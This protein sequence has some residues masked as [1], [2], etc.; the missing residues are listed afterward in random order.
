V[1]SNII[2]PIFCGTDIRP[3]LRLP[4]FHLSSVDRSFRKT[5][6]GNISTSKSCMFPHISQSINFENSDTSLHYIEHK[7]PKQT[8]NSVVCRVCNSTLSLVPNKCFHGTIECVYDFL[9]L[10]YFYVRTEETCKY[11][12]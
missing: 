8:V 1:S 10:F 9:F 4:S 3:N 11:N 5:W 12:I 7:I 6:Q 2:Y